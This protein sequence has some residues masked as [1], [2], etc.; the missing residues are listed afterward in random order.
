MLAEYLGQMLLS[1]RGGERACGQGTFEGLR[2]SLGRARVG[3]RI[4]EQ[5]ADLGERR[6][7][8]DPGDGAVGLADDPQRGV[9]R[10]ADVGVAQHEGRGRHGQVLHS[11]S[12][13][14]TSRP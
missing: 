3:Q 2:D 8:D 14:V 6:L 4:G 7:L 11:G 10:D 13:V 9:G 12:D 5:V 1:D